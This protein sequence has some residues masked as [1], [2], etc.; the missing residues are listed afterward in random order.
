MMGKLNGKKAIVT[1]ASRGIGREI[2]GAFAKEGASVFLSADGTEEELRRAAEQCLAAGGGAGTFETGVFNL[3]EP[4]S[5]EKM[6]E[7]ALKCLGRI[8]ILVNNAGIRRHLPFGEFTH[9]DFEQVVAVNLR[10]A[11]FSS[12]A[13]LPSMRAA[14]GGRIIHIASQLGVVAA[15]RTAVYGITKAG[16]IHLTRVMALELAGEGIEVNAISPGPTATEY[17]LQRL[18]KDPEDRR[19]RLADVPAGRFAE[20]EEIAAAA[21]FLASGEA[22]F[23]QGHNLIIDGGYVAH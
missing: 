4:G 21:V 23:I 3:A 12:Q 13:V 9:E 20:P 10:A 22:S 16:L 6:V 14:G 8:D 19:Q 7:A 5:P 15:R 17:Y 1:G 11:F 18:E 2:A